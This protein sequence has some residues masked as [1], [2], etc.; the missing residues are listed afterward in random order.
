M[1]SRSR[2][3]KSEEPT[4]ERPHEVTYRRAEKP[5]PTETKPVEKKENE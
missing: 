3:L 5:A 4:T 1:T 2:N